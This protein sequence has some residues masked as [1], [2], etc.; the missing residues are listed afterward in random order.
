MMD[1]SRYLK[2]G[3]GLWWGQGPA[4]PESLVNALIEQ[5]QRLGAIR[6]FSGLSLNPK[7]GA[8]ENDSLII[9]SYGGLGELRQLS[10]AGRLGVIPCHYS[11]LPRLFEQG[12]LPTDVGLIQVSSPNAKGEVSLGLGVDYM[13]D[14]LAHTKILIAEVNSAMPWV[15]SA[16]SLPLS[17]FAEVIHVDRPLREMATRTPDAVDQAIAGHVAALIND[18]ETIQLGV[19]SLPNAVLEQLKGHRRLGFHGGMVTD[20]VGE[21][22]SRGVITGEA[23]EIDTGLAVTG[24]AMGST[25][26][27][28]RIPELPL[29]LRPTSYTHSP[30]VLSK[31]KSLVSINSALEIDLVGQVAAE[32]VGGIYLGAIGGQTDFSRAAA[33]TG[34]RSIIALRSEN[35]GQS[36]IRPSL[37]G[38]LVATSRP[39]VDVVV[40]EFGSAIL[41]GCTLTQRAEKLAAIAAPHH[42]EGLLHALKKEEI[43]S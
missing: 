23:K 24:T 37:S 36:T 27:Y 38:S 25:E 35:R 18:G 42:R 19:G 5:A 8:L 39:D 31:L 17:A 7:V 12:H 28:R 32:T 33:L 10:K 26:F 4:E 21:L 22:I 43:F 6:A 14:A 1:F 29:A 40:T 15:P 30:Q 11:A 41:T 16:P 9:Q 13:A 34:A 20:A 2:D 3:D